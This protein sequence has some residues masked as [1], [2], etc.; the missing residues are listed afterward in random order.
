[1]YDEDVLLGVQVAL[2]G[3][4]SKEAALNTLALGQQ[5]QVPYILDIKVFVTRYTHDSGHVQE[6]FSAL[7]QNPQ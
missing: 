1:M 2:E 4:V 3:S 5:P 7:W 6:S